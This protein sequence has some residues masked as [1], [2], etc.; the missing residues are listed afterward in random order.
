MW[1][2]D[3]AK[4]IAQWAMQCSQNVTSEA[5]VMLVDPARI[6]SLYAISEQ[7]FS[8]TS[9]HL[10]ANDQAWLLGSHFSD[11]RCLQRRQGACCVA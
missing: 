4:C 6:P 7:D 5:R 10:F 3:G 8:L 11:N 9:E 1:I 2:G